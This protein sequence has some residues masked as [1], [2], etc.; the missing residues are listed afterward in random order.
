[1]TPLGHDQIPR[2]CPA[3]QREADVEGRGWELKQGDRLVGIL[4]FEAQDMFWS[5][6]RSL[7]A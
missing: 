4:V 2:Y 6:C 3:V 1:M 7:C 5:D